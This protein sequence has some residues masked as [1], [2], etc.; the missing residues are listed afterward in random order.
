MWIATWTFF[1]SPD[2]IVQKSLDLPDL[3][4]HAKIS[5]NAKLTNFLNQ[6]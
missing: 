1:S 4:R 5:F 2:D 6:N 3:Q